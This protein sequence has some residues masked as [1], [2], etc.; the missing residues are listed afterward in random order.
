MN[1]KINE[2]NNN[3]KFR[4]AGLIINDNKFLTCQIMK[5]GFYC[6]PGGH[7]QVNEN[8]IETIKREI[9]EETGLNTEVVK[10]KAVIENFFTRPNN[11]NYA[12]SMN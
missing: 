2:N 11:T 5:K 10:L 12:S 3:F 8:T 9:K 1:I 7:S 4:V 6:L